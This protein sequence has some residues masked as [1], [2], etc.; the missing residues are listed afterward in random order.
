[1]R[2]EKRLTDGTIFIP[3]VEVVED[4]GGFPYTANV[5]PNCGYDDCALPP[6]C[7][8]CGWK[9]EACICGH[10]ATAEETREPRFCPYCGEKLRFCNCGHEEKVK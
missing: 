4:V 3:L 7:S 6:R 9:I 2:D 8:K 5:C 10:E 1:M